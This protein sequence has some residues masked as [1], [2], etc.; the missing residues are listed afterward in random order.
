MSHRVEQLRV[1][2]CDEEEDIVA[3]LGGGH[4]LVAV[5]GNPLVCDVTTGKELAMAQQGVDGLK[6]IRK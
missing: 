6:N 3:D 5:E 4:L 1:G 2:P